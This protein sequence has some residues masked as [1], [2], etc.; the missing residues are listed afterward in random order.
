MSPGL[1]VGFLTTGPP[2]KVPISHSI[3]TIPLQAPQLV[4]VIFLV[5]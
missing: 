4:V 2:G 1:E 3:D 5:E